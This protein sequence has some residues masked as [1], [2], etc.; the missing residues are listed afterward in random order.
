MATIGRPKVALVVTEMER[1][2]LVRL[3]KRAHV[4]RALAFRARLVLACTDAVPNTAVARRRRT[5]N[6]TVGKWRTR[7]IER[8]LD[9][10]YDEPRIGAPRTIS[11]EAVEAVIVKTL[12][13][14]P[15]GETHWS[16]RTM[17]AK[18]GMS[19]TMIGRIWRTFGLKPHITQSF[20]LSPDP[21]LV[22]KIRDVVGLYMNPPT[23]AVVFSFDEKSQ[24]QALERAQPILPMDI[25][26]PNGGP[27]T[28]SGM[29][30]STSSPPSMSRRAKSW[31]AANSGI[32]RRISSRSC[33]RSTRASNP[34][35][36]CTSCWITCRPTERRRCSD[37]CSAI[38][39]CIFISRRPM[40]RG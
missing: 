23:N 11:D 40:R 17:A 24:I 39:T 2:E 4:N 27:T 15:K 19:H 36:R 13:T 25:G 22:D 28:T 35:W 38:R 32:A 3:T 33:V 16:T 21:Q 14:T 34:G 26:S 9:G 30:R 6:A 1:R 20:K 5:S 37:G 10:L 12:E 7:F 31:R 18:A 8:R 29:A